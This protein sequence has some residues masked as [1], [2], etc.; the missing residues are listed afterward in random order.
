MSDRNLFVF[1]I[2]QQ[3]VLKWT[4]LKQPTNEQV[5]KFA[6]QCMK[7]N[8]QH[9][10]YLFLFCLLPVKTKTKYLKYKQL[11]TTENNKLDCIC[12]VLLNMLHHLL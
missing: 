3:M 5:C 2:V 9:C 7:Y 10:P 4:F 11:V 8:R 12:L 6:S 1:M